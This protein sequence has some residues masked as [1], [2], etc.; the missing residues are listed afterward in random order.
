MQ[1]LI[2]ATFALPDSVTVERDY[3]LGEHP[4]SIELVA[5]GTFASNELSSVGSVKTVDTVHSQHTCLV[6]TD[7]VLCVAIAT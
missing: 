1:R 4:H 6:F 7:I 5:K 3:R 2:E